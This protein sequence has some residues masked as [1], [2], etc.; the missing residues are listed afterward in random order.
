MSRGMC[1]DVLDAPKRNRAALWEG[2]A[3]E[4]A[5]RGARVGKQDSVGTA[6]ETGAQQG[7]AAL[8]FTPLDKVR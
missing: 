4:G 8:E 5:P 6:S 2:L 1:R 3:G 7:E